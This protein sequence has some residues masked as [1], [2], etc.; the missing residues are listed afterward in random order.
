MNRHVTVKN[1][2]L[3]R[4]GTFD[5]ADA[6]VL[7]G[8]NNAGKFRIDP[9]IARHVESMAVGRSGTASRTGPF[10]I[11]DSTLAPNACPRDRTAAPGGGRA[12]VRNHGATALHRVRHAT[13][14]AAPR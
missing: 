13:L 8:S 14:P 1:F 12:E 3:F 4:E 7:A 10:P 9:R 6:V 5:L 2:E 11:R